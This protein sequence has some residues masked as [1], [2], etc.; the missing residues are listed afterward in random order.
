MRSDSAPSF[1]ASGRACGFTLVEL[2]VVIVVIGMLSA[3]GGGLISK[4]AGGYR[5]A[6]DQ[7][8]NAGLGRVAME[9]MVRELR[10]AV[11][12]SVQVSPS[13]QE[14]TFLRTFDAGRYVAVGASDSKL[15]MD[16]K[17][18]EP[19]TAYGL[20]GL[21]GDDHQLVVYP[22][23]ADEV[24]ASLAAS[25]SGPRAKFRP[26]GAYQSGTAYELRDGGQ[27]SYH[28]PSP[29][30]RIYAVEHAVSFCYEPDSEAL[31]MAVKRIND[32]VPKDFCGTGSRLLAKP[33]QATEFTFDAAELTRNA[34]VRIELTAGPGET[35]VT[36]HHEV[37]IRN[38]P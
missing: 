21:D 18:N 31:H 28:S 29:R 11:P 13:G 6:V 25:A 9:R 5:A 4:L 3:V 8:E 23:K 10:R 2:V 14:V 27:F 12:N 24:L 17:K 20:S 15:N 30:R 19:F 34:I 37:H 35:P 38:V 33:I 1:T 16:L 32:G 22:L 36:F 26:I 7:T